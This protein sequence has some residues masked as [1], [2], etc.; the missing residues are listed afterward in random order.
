[1]DIREQVQENIVEAFHDVLNG[2]KKHIRE[3]R[4]NA[5]KV[6]RTVSELYEAHLERRDKYRRESENIAREIVK[7]NRR[8]DSDITHISSD[9]I[10]KCRTGELSLVS[11]KTLLSN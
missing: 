3:G 9:C 6:K 5:T 10:E 11:F 8:V 7:A 1:M 2:I 4:D